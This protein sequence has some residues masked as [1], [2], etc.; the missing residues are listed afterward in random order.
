MRSLSRWTL[1]GCL[2]VVG[3]GGATAAPPAGQKPFAAVP[4]EVAAT[5][6]DAVAVAA[7]SSEAVA[8]ADPSADAWT[9]LGRRA[10]GYLD[11]VTAEVARAG[12]GTFLFVQTLASALPESPRVLP[13]ETSVGWAVCIDVYPFVVS[14]LFGQVTIGSPCQFIVRTSWDGA[15]FSGELLDRRSAGAADPAAGLPFDPVVDGTS[16]RMAIP[17]AA[18]G[19]PT[20]FLW[21]MFTEELGSLGPSAAHHVDAAPGGG[22]GAPLAWPAD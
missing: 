10:P 2:A 12:D 16:V 15:H 4:A 3:C 6:S 17:A 20:L 5:T 22:A 21:S 9:M 14:P 18:L 7:T 19:D 1:I 11:I 8:V 13:G